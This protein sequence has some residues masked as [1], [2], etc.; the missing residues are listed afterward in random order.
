V[1]DA[2]SQ[3]GA[4][5]DSVEP[6]EARILSPLD[7]LIVQR[8]RLR[9]LFDFDYQLESYVPVAK[10]RYGHFV[11]LWGERFAAR[12]EAKALRER[13]KLVLTGLWFEPGYEKNRNF[14]KA[15]Y[16]GLEKFAAFTPVVN[17]M[18]GTFTWLVFH[19]SHFGSWAVIV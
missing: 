11:L 10:R 7:N 18:R 13:S 3:L 14:R 8:E 16:T 5:P 4:L 6:T 9:W 17:W 2:V 15:F 19:L 1:P 12:L